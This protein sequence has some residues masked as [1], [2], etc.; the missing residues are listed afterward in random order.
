MGTA[1]R[2]MG[3]KKGAFG[4]ILSMVEQV[5]GMG[6]EVRWLPLDTPQP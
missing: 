3:N 6:L 2:E 5:N 4:K 1:W